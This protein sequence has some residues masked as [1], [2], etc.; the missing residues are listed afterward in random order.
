MYDGD[1][2]VIQRVIKVFKPT[3]GKTEG[4]CEYITQYTWVLALSMIPSI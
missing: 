3:K 2:Q 1:S 4:F